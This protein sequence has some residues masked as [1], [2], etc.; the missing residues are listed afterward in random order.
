VI[1]LTHALKYREGIAIAL[2]T[3]D[4]AYVV[5]APRK[6]LAVSIIEIAMWFAV[7]AFLVLRV[8]M[9]AAFIVLPVSIVKMIHRQ[10]T[11]PTA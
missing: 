5:F 9:L 1:H 10:S 6:G 4:T 8:A 7:S 2:R 11:V 3:D